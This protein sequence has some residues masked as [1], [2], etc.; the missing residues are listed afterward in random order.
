MVQNEIDDSAKIEILR[1]MYESL[2]DEAKNSYAANLIENDDLMR[3]LIG[4][5]NK[6]NEKNDTEFISTGTFIDFLRRIRE[7]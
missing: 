7:E 3:R 2:S 1:S 5:L 6:M 4:I